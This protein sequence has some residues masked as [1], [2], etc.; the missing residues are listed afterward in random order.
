L[1]IVLGQIVRRLRTEFRLPIAH[2]AVLARL[3]RDGPATTS[4]LAGAERIRPQSMAQTIADLAADGLVDR[5][6]DRE[7]RRQVLIAITGRG[8]QVLIRD[9]PRR[10]GWLAHAIV[11]ELTAEEQD[12]L[13]R[14]VP[15]L[16]RLSQS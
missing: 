4:S 6:R 10:D 1:R 5:T 14:T 15:I 7:D 12:L 13:S 8:R 16:R 3:E 11:T 2:G 9:R